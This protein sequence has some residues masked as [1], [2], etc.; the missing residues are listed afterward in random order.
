M[1]VKKSF[2]LISLSCFTGY[3]DGGAYGMYDPNMGGM[4]GGF[5]MFNGETD[6]TGGGG[7]DYTETVTE[8]NC[9]VASIYSIDENGIKI[10][11]MKFGKVKPMK[12]AVPVVS[13]PRPVV[14]SGGGKGVSENMFL[15]I[16]PSPSFLLNKGL[17][18]SSVGFTP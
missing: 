12:R 5:E 4:N 13:Q 11:K 3:Y 15:C 9:E 7:G 18:S 16:K 1:Q 17:S 10:P 14:R 2:N 8:D 6:Y